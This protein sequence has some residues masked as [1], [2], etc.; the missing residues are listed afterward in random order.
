M[1][2]R[3]LLAA[4]SEGQGSAP[5]TH[6][7]VHNTQTHTEGSELR[8]ECDGGTR[9]CILHIKYSLDSFL[10]KAFS[11]FLSRRHFMN[12]SL[13]LLHS[14]RKKRNTVS[15]LQR[16]GLT[17]SLG[18]LGAVL[19][20]PSKFVSFLGSGCGIECMLGIQSPGFNPHHFKTK[21]K[22]RGEEMAHWL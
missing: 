16:E 1:A 14:P 5:S 21:H 13:K 12:F 18:G 15:Y 6:M 10:H 19:W 2:Q 4:H 11:K 3:L 22:T 7:V 9:L 8:S 17:G 20:F